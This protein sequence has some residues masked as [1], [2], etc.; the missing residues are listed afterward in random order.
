MKRKNSKKWMAFLVAA[1][2][3]VATGCGGGENEGLEPP[4]QPPKFNKS[5]MLLPYISCGELEAEIKQ[6]L[7]DEMEDKLEAL[8]TQCRY[9]CNYGGGGDE[10]ASSPAPADSSGDSGSGGEGSDPSMTATNLVEA[11]VDEADLIKADSTHAFA[12]VDNKVK[13]IRVWPFLKFGEV[14][15]ITPAGKPEGLYLAGDRLVIL[16]QK[17]GYSNF[18]SESPYNGSSQNE[19]AVVSEV[20]D[21]S[22]PASPLLINKSAYPGEL[23]D[24]RMIKAKMHLVISNQ[25]TLPNLDYTIDWNILPVCPATG[26]AEP[27]D[28]VLSAIDELRKKNLETIENIEINIL[29]PAA[30]DNTL[31]CGDI[32]RSTASKGA[33]F[34]TVV[35]DDITN[36]DGAEGAVSIAGSGGS[37]YASR[38]GLYVA[39]VPNP[40]AMYKPEYKDITL[41]HRF[42]LGGNLPTYTGSGVVNGHLLDNDYVGSKYSSRF[43]M[44]QFALSEHK[45][46]L[47]V[48]TT[49]VSVSGGGSA[50]SESLV[51]V[52]DTKKSDLEVVGQVS[53]LGK[54]ERIYA[55]RFIGDRGFVV[56]F[57]KVDPLYIIDLSEPIEPKVAG[58]LKIPGFSTY[59]HPFDQDYIIGLGFG[60]DDMG[61]FAWTQGIKLALFD[62]SDPENPTEVGH[63]VIGSRG[64]Y[65]A[66][67]EE[68]HAF[69]LDIGRQILALPIE[70]YEGSPGGSQLGTFSFAGVMLMHA[71]LSGG[72]D[73]IGDIVLTDI[74]PSNYYGF[75][76]SARA[77]RTIIIGDGEDEGVITLTSSGV[78][79][80]RIDENMS[81]VGGVK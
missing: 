42:S 46:F 6:V 25:L 61:N 51:S 79:L 4:H 35:T 40:W 27:T 3:F 44:N 2:I 52:M 9:T 60:G 38:S 66:A 12:I 31:S 55:V 58:E 34:L 77:L 70:L 15:T 45:G 49:L 5:V 57:K 28:A 33:S 14:A 36:S 39:S 41:I 43:S 24:S 8:N 62:I 32:Y 50:S 29:L 21:V 71:D 59:L 74:G 53:G 7:I 73:S 69:T 10:V 19:E 1:F 68:H 26:Q 48:A 76:S 30:D 20:F 16:S 64:T 81:E 47:R 75:T 23:I 80:H 65:S 18:Y 72:F 11:G 54:G 67:V 63:R 22:D 37:V 78:Y 13:I 17:G 56:T